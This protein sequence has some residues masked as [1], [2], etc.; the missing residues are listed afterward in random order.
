MIFLIRKKPYISATTS[1]M[2]PD[3]QEAI[4]RRQEFYNSKSVDDF[5]K[6]TAYQKANM[7]CV[8]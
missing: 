8:A 1:V 2:N 4:G 6:N 5:L 7:Q 3:S